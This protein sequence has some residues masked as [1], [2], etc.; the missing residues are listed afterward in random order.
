MRTSV[1]AA[2][3]DDNDTGQ[4]PVTLYDA[5]G[6]VITGWNGGLIIARQAVNLTI[7]AS[8]VVSAGSQSGQIAC[9]NLE[10]LLLFLN[11][12]AA[13]GTTPEL[14]VFLDT[15]DDYG[16]TWYQLAQLGPANIAAVG[17]YTLGI[18]LGSSTGPFGNRLR[19]RWTVAGTTPSFTFAVKAVGK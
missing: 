9:D 15:S 10:E 3:V 16:A 2:T 4:L 12:T 18:G 19:V 1:A 8:S 5:A 17:Q 14:N 11:V 7:L 6:N 13:S